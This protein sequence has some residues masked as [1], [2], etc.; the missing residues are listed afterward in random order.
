M[1]KLLASRTDTYPAQPQAPDAS[2]SAAGI[3][4]AP[5]RREQS[6]MRTRDGH[7]AVRGH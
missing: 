5:S 3:G 2:P 4:L 7:D 6:R 1:L